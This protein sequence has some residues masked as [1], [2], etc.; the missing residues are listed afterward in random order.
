MEERDQP[1]EA[2]WLNESMSN[3]DVKEGNVRSL[4]FNCPVLVEAMNW[5]AS[6]LSVLYGEANGSELPPIVLVHGI[7]GFDGDIY[8][9]HQ[10][11]DDLMDSGGA[12]WELLGERTPVPLTSKHLKQRWMLI[13]LRRVVYCFCRCTNA[14]SFAFENL[15]CH[16]L[17]VHLV[18]QGDKDATLDETI[19]Y[20]N[21]L[22][23]QAKEALPEGFKDRIGERGEV[24]VDWVQEEL[25]LSHPLVGCFVSHCGFV[26]MWESLVNTCQIILVPHAGDQFVNAKFMTR[27]LKVVVDVDGRE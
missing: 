8:C 24:H 20:I 9:L 10:Q 1:V 17:N 25:I 26:S 11:L 3:K 21:Y 4:S 14:I 6:Q 13:K 2:H 16:I 27:E 22:Q 7:F 12:T 15:P 19:D 5:L 23:L 18:L